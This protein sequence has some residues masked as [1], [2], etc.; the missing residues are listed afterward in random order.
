MLPRSTEWRDI[1]VDVELW[2]DYDP[3][4]RYRPGM[5]LGTRT[6]AGAWRQSATELYE[7]GARCVRIAEPVTICGNV[8]VQSGRTLVLIRELTSHGFAVEWRAVCRDGCVALRRL[9][10]LYPP[11]EVAGAP[12]EATRDWRATFFPC[13]CV[14]RRGPGFIEVRDRRLGSLE[15]FTIDDPRHIAA[16][17]AISEGVAADEVPPDV[18]C[19]LAEA[20]LLAEHAGYLWWLPM[21]VRR[22]PFP[23]M[24]V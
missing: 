17:E 12:E 15:M 23:S 4:V 19:D 10:H 9:N 14:C 18:R 3:V 13:K 6:L 1:S 16:I 20:D 11:I 22:W 7:A 21:R 8:S 2:R 5:R 24:A